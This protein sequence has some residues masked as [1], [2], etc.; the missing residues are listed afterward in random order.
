MHQYR[1]NR[2][3]LSALDDLKHM[4]YDI[5]LKRL[6]VCQ[7]IYPTP[8]QIEACIFSLINSSMCK[9]LLMQKRN[10]NHKRIIITQSRSEDV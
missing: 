6:Y 3:V 4:D 7:L 5:K 10:N 8:I 9:L 2:Y 1:M